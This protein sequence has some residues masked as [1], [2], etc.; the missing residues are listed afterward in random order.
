MRL[1]SEEDGFLPVLL[2]CYVIALPFATG[3]IGKSFI[4]ADI[5]LLLLIATGF[6]RT[7]VSGKLQANPGDAG[8][9][10]LVGASFAGKHVL[11]EPQA[12]AFELGSL[13]FM[14]FGARV[15]AGYINDKQQFG[16]LLLLIARLIICLLMASLAAI[17]LRQLGE[18]ELT[19]FFFS[20][21]GSFKGLFNFTN[22]MAIFLICFWPL[23]IMREDLGSLKRFVCY[24]MLLAVMVSVAS[25][26]G[27]WIAV[28]QTII[29]ELIFSR[30]KK[31]MNTFLRFSALASVVALVI[32]LLATDPGLHR[33]LGSL[34]HAPLSFDEPRIKNFREAFNSAPD[35]L[36]GYGLGCFD[37][38]HVH[39]VHNT[40]F[41]VLVE[42]GVVGFMAFM[43]IFAFYA[44]RF[45]RS[46]EIEGLPDLKLALGL[47]WSG[48]ISM[49]M[50]HY[51][52]R[53]RSVWLILAL[54]IAFI[55]LQP[56]P[57]NE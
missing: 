20:V 13:V 19:E 37:Q 29:I 47:A 44:L 48:I 39:E 11:A 1:R 50:F 32:S 15:I 5:F 14:Y 53:N 16:K 9:L 42:T 22:Q 6:Y 17:F 36:R 34:E 3:I 56:E 28:G 33:S 24:F 7:L 4:V 27:F 51:L 49:G 26:S 55:A 2:C 43:A 18:L 35:W 23:T 30:G 8:F 57:K 10:I 54:T 38:K 52:L 46:S 21:H 12:F 45:F 41:S 40:P 31:R 25:R